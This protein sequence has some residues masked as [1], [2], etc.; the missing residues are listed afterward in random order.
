MLD[1]PAL[2]INKTLSTSSRADATDVV[3]TKHV[4]SRLG[5]FDAGKHELTPFPDAPLFNGISAFQKANDLHVDGVMRPEGE[6]AKALGGAFGRSFRIDIARRNRAGKDKK[7][8]E[9]LLYKVDMPTCLALISHRGSNG[10]RAVALCIASAMERYSKC[11]LGA[12]ASELPPLN[13][14]NN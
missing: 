8:C 6:T 11:Y 9:H 4:L 12:S 1:F 13:T 14:Y 10:P 3:L 5:H 7:H 2:P